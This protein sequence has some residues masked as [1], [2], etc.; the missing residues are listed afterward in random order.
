MTAPA[1]C[2]RLI[3]VDLPIGVVS[4]HARREKNLR[5][6]HIST[7]HL[8]WAR[9][10]LAACRAVLLASLWPDP[11][12]PLCP[13]RF[14]EKAREVLTELFGRRRLRDPLVL[15]RTLLEFIGAFANWDLAES[16]RDL[17]IARTLVQEA[18]EALGGAP[19]TAPVVVD[20]F[21]G[22]GAIPLEALRVG[23]EP[24]ASDLNAVAVLINTMQL[25]QIPRHGARL[26]AAFRKWGDWV[27]AE[28]AKELAPFYPADPDGSTPL[29][30][31]WAR[32]IRCEGPGCGATV[33][34]IRATFINQQRPPVHLVVGRKTKPIPVTLKRGPE[35]KDAS[36]A[37]VKG[38]KATCPACGFTT[39]AKAVKLQLRKRDGGA[40]DAR[41]LTVLVDRPGSGRDFRAP[42][43]EDQQ[44]VERAAEAAKAVAGEIP[45]TPLNELRPYKN[46]PG[47]SI[48]PSIGIRRVDHLPTPRQKLMLAAL[49]RCVRRV[50]EEVRKGDDRDLA[51]ALEVLFAFAVS[52]M[53]NQH[54]SL[55]RWNT[56]RSTTEGLFSKQALQVMWD[57][58]EG[59]PLGEAS[60][61]WDGAIHWIALVVEHCAALPAGRGTVSHAD[62]TARSTATEESADVL[63]TD[64]PYFAAIPYADVS[65]I[66]YA[67]LRQCIGERRPE[68]FREEIPDATRELTVTNSVKGPNDATKD[69]A[70]FQKGMCDALTH[71]R[72]ATRHDG[73]GC[74]VFADSSTQSWE[75]LLA[76]V[77]DA[78]WVVTASWPIHTER[79]ARTRALQSASLQSS[80]FLV[81]RPRENPD[82]SLRQ[83]AVG[84][85]S[86]VRAELPERIAA[87]M[88]RLA[89]E[90][91]TGADAIFASL[92]PALE[93]YSRYSRV[94]RPDGEA[95]AL[96]DYLREVW[97]QVAQV[98][99]STIFAGADTSG[100]EADARLTAMWLWTLQASR[101]VAGDDAGDDA[102]DDAAE[103]DAAEDDADD[104]EDDDEEST[105]RTRGKAPKGYP[106]EYDAALHIAMGLGARLE[107]HVGLVE[108]AKGK[109][110]L[111]AVTERVAALFPQTAAAA[112]AVKKS[113]KGQGEFAFLRE[114]DDRKAV[115]LL[116]EL[117]P[118]SVQGTL[119]D[120]VH[121]AMLLFHHN[122]TGALK[123]H[124]QRYGRGS[125]FWT[126]T[127][128]LAKLYPDG[129]EERRMLAGLLAR[130][131]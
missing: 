17:A 29:A 111:R 30:Y 85:W 74:V 82:G 59:V 47:T 56:K 10:P 27:K 72:I 54:S 106:L 50:R 15:R 93:I 16:Q 97:A 20:P 48:V 86:V 66:F 101:P 98:A 28:A 12:D 55:S 61:N 117:G 120:R 109:A 130:R 63:F 45:T 118:A 76:A 77:I 90:G 113:R 112:T 71:A 1:L 125:A 42:T 75:S 69:A 14:R 80:I 35:P 32:T 122:R 95:V 127:D 39:S 38:G 37:T 8:W 52:R 19:G 103:D 24:L 78:G 36:T 13:E 67:W 25:E 104:E 58:V 23:A 73:I 89:K 31:L 5:H 4:Q 49:V 121:Q 79:V 83:D 131:S 7:L 6:G 124:L 81:C 3:E 60:A 11:A 34:L 18:H 96:R 33:P 87:W 105:G 119:L 2:K 43:P 94:E 46:T 114:E 64:P 68:L 41:L 70:Y 26:A 57:F 91:I 92:G 62:A 115:A 99:L 21:A 110:R 40:D 100:F 126:L 84:E 116:L 129:T 53:V 22:G 102:E 44:I 88:T 123:E 65:R 51:E 9:R 108:V 128:S 107:D